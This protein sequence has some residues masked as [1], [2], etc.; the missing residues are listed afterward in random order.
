MILVGLEHIKRKIRHFWFNLAPLL[1]IKVKIWT[2]NSVFVAFS[3]TNKHNFDVLD[4]QSLKIA[5]LPRR[6][7]RQ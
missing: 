3:V 5:F 6:N 2:R 4:I 1:G 7:R